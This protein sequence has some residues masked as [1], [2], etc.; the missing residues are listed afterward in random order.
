MDYIISGTDPRVGT[1]V[2]VFFL[3]GLLTRGV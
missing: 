1:G 2:D 3:V